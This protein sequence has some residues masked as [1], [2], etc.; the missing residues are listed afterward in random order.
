MPLRMSRRD[1]LKAGILGAGALAREDGAA[2]LALAAE[3]G[4]KVAVL[5]D[6]RASVRALPEGT[7]VGQIVPF[8]DGS[9]ATLFGDGRFEVTSPGDAS[10]LAFEN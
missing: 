8:R 2:V 9:T 10:S 1:L 3:L 5:A 7:L 4:A 6:G